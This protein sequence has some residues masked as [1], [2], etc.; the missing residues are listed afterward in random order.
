M[1]KKITNSLIVGAALL[2]SGVMPSCSDYD[3]DIDSLNNRVSVVETSIAELQKKISDGKWITS[4]EQSATGYVLTLSDG[5]KLEIKNG[6]A[7]KSEQWIID[8]KTKEW[9][10]I[11][12]EGQKHPSGV[13]AEGKDGTAGPVG[14]A[15]EK[16]KT[17]F[18]KNG[19]WVIENEKGELVELGSAVGQSSYVIDRKAYWELRV[20]KENAK[21]END[22]ES[23]I[24]PKTASITNIE[25]YSNPDIT[26]DYMPTLEEP[27]LYL[28][29]GKNEQ[30]KEVKFNGKTYYPGDVLINQ[31]NKLILQ[32]NPLT[33]DASL[34]NF[35][36]N[37][38]KGNESLFKVE[39]ITKNMSEKPVQSRSMT[40]N[41]GLWDVKLTIERG[42]NLANYNNSTAY[43]L[44]TTTLDNK[45]TVVASRYDINIMIDYAYGHNIST[46]LRDIQINEEMSWDKFFDIV[47][48]D[49]ASVADYYLEI[50]ED[51][52]N[53]AGN[54]GIMLN[55]EKKTITFTKAQPNHFSGIYIHYLKMNGE[56]K[57]ELLT[58]RAQNIQN[59]TLET[60]F[61][62]T[63][64]D[65]AMK[66]TVKVAFTEANALDI[67]YD[68]KSTSINLRPYFS[69]ADPDNVTV[70]GVKVN[71]N[72]VNFN[73]VLPEVEFKKENGQW[74]AYM[75]FDE[76]KVY[77]TTYK[78]EIT[79]HNYDNNQSRKLEFDININAPQPFDWINHRNVAFFE[80]NNVKAYPN[81]PNKN[82][83]SLKEIYNIDNKDWDNIYFNDVVPEKE[84]TWFASNRYLA[85]IPD[86]NVNGKPR[87]VTAYY[88][89]FN[90]LH[91]NASTYKFNLDI[92]SQIFDG[93]IESQKEDYQVNSK[94]D[95]KVKVDDF[96]YFDVKGKKYDALKD[97]RVA[98][99]EVTIT[100]GQEYLAIKKDAE[101]GTYVVF[102]KDKETVIV[103]PVT[104]KVKVSV[105]DVWGKKKECTA[106]VIVK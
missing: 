50:P 57:K 89:P 8:E 49:R 56:V 24:L 33:A 14:P 53:A 13:I 84:T 60:N 44:Q 97:N 61:E 11:D 16:G 17:P 62:W 91:L 42:A 30:G 32:T 34:Y 23:I 41:K 58:V 93:K 76:T 66:K 26:T 48:G 36:L 68:S 63:V 102:R 70:D 80:G 96:T 59:V 77:A 101:N 55:K 38:S 18:I 99:V 103:T 78:A 28:N 87:E 69:F 64:T 40:E 19:S 105:T 81:M 83:Y 71:P 7:G 5:S 73:E 82:N 22:F 6:T 75:T 100:E 31:S 67:I 46:Q 88:K 27:S 47:S 29:I 72:E 39:S 35:T 54:Y 1:N 3:D 9:V 79:F 21:D 90:N 92:R 106:N 12:S 25:V 65:N 10:R 98:K 95:A 85:N 104:C 86:Y 74:F 15:G 45:S 2:S 51:Q 43:S 52:K 4:M 94:D 37:D 20:A